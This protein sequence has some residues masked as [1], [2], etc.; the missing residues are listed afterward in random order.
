MDSGK[1]DCVLLIPELELQKSYIDRHVGNCIRVQTNV[2]SLINQDN[3][4]CLEVAVS[5]SRRDHKI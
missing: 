5:N 3:W 4:I 2:H 1:K